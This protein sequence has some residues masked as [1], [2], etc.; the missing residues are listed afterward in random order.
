MTQGINDHSLGNLREVM[1]SVH[2]ENMGFGL[3]GLSFALCKQIIQGYVKSIC[4][5]RKHHNYTSIPNFANRLSKINIIT[6][7]A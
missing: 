7:G 3:R 1:D 6:S 2:I 4:N 5:S